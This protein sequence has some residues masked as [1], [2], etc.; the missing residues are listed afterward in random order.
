[1]AENSNNSLP[2]LPPRDQLSE[3]LNSITNNSVKSNFSFISNN[4]YPIENLKPFLPPLRDDNSR[5]GDEKKIESKINSGHELQGNTDSQKFESNLNHLSLD[6]QNEINS[7][8]KEEIFND[9]VVLNSR[10]VTN[11]V[12]ICRS[13]CLRLFVAD[14]LLTLN[15]GC[16]EE[17]ANWEYFLEF[18]PENILSQSRFIN[19]DLQILVGII[20]IL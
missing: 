13:L 18:F 19:K 8:K 9:L 15:F 7:Q 17:T 2:L 10:V 3:I 14:S 20:F 16:P 4:F 12:Q 1:M 6:K 11:Q 5:N